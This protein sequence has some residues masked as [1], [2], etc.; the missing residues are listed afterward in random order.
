MFQDENVNSNLNL[1]ENVVQPQLK[2]LITTI[3]QVDTSLTK[4]GKRDNGVIK[5]SI[6]KNVP[7]IRPLT[8]FIILNSW[9]NKFVKNVY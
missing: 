5:H 9:N 4:I 7:I 8:K 3:N 1:E 6:F 2:N